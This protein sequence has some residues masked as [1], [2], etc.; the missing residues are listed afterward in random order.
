[1]LLCQFSKEEK[2]YLALT[3]IFKL[4]VNAF[5]ILYLSWYKLFDCIFRFILLLLKYFIILYI[6]SNMLTVWPLSYLLKSSWPPIC[7]LILVMIFNIKLCGEI[8]QDS[9]P[10]SLYLKRFIFSSWS[11]LFFLELSSHLFYD[12][13]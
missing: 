6:S 2:W 1:M 12:Y 9:L 10:V 7:I 13:F 3:C 5:Y 8:S 4:P 11:H